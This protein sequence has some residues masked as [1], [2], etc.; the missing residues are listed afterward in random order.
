MCQILGLFG[1]LQDMALSLALSCSGHK[2]SLIKWTF[3]LFTAL[4]FFLK[5]ETFLLIILYSYWDIHFCTY[6][7]MADKDYFLF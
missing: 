3:V 7:V 1:G 6:L 5:I 4:V 2:I